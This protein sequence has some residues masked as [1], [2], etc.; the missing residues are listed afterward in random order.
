MEKKYEDV[1]RRL[2]DIIK[3]MKPGEKLPSERELIDE[4]GY[5]RPTI[6]KALTDLEQLGIIYR[7]P[8]QGAFVADKKLKK[9]LN[10]LLSFAEDL[11]LNGD[12]PMTNLLTYQIIPA[13]ATVAEKLHLN[14]G[15]SVA[16]IIR[17]RFKNGTPIIYDDSYFA[18]FSIENITCNDLV[19]SIYSYVEKHGLS[20]YMAEEVF[21]AVI[22]PLNVAAYLEI[23]NDKPV[24]RIDKV[25]YLSDERPFEYTISYKNP[26]KYYLEIK[27]YR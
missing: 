20:V 14:V 18:L 3:K 13:D 2:L 19:T 27:S 24:I 26:D 11:A 5:S 7:L 6:Q 12:V 10:K 8:R 25:A 15:D 1:K 17:L 22:V 21:S 23:D 16:H 9:T 4:I